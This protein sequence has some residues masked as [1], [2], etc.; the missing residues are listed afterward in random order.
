MFA[1]PPVSLSSFL[2]LYRI[3]PDSPFLFSSARMTGTTNCFTPSGGGPDPNE[4]HVI[5][6]ALLYDSQNVGQ[7]CP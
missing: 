3:L 4:C 2:P 1:V 5:A 6:D 7:Y